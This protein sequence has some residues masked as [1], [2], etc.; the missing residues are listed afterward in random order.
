MN[1]DN[2]ISLGTNTISITVKG[3]STGASRT[4]VAT[5]NVIKLNL[6]STFQIARSIEENTP[7]DVTYTVEGDSDKI[8]EFYI[9][10]VL[11]YNPTV[12]SLEPI[13]TKVQSIGG[14]SAGKHTLQM[15]AKMQIG[16]SQFRSKLLY[17]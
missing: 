15:Q 1:I 9:D 7:F 16:E 10:G 11:K 2:F 14:L 5:Y 8:V 6:S 4:V 13:A 17:Y 12:S 3:R